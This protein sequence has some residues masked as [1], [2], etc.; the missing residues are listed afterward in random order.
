MADYLTTD[1][2]LTSVADAIRSKGGTSASLVYPSGFVSAIQAISTGTDVSDTTAAAGD[3]RTGKY[4]YTSAGV[5]T[6]GSIA[7]QAAQTITPT[8]SDQT[9]AS[10]KYLTGAQ[11]I[12]GDA[13]LL[14]ENIAEGV[15]I[16]GIQGTH[17]GGSTAIV[18]EKDVN[19]YDFDG[20]LLYAYTAS[21]FSALTELPDLQ[22]KEGFTA[23]GWNW[24]LAGA[25][26]YVQN[27]G[28]LDIGQTCITS[29]G[30]TRIGFYFNLNPSTNK[31]GIPLSQTVS[32]GTVIE[33]GDGNSTTVSG[34]SNQTVYHQ[35]STR[36]K[37]EITI[38]VNSGVLTI[39]NISTYT[40]SDTN[41]G[42]L[43]LPYAY[44]GSNIQVKN[45]I[46]YAEVINLPSGLDNARDSYSG[47]DCL[48]VEVDPYGW[49]RPVYSQYPNARSK[50]IYAETI[51]TLKPLG[52]G[53]YSQC[54]AKITRVTIPAGV[55]A[56]NNYYCAGN[57]CLQYVVI[58]DSVLTVG[59]SAFKSC[60]RLQ[61]VSIP[62]NVT[63]IDGSAFRSCSKLREVHVKA[64][65]PPTLGSSAIP[66][67]TN[68]VIYVPSASLSAYQS[69][70]N[71]SSY[72]SKMVGE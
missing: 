22:P 36:G 63:S 28:M 48:H 21:E 34:T 38:T 47:G 52:S 55:T 20:S 35:Y 17:S 9:I 45:R 49:T 56:V 16:F 12:K 67:N 3:V 43:D 72:A 18:K 46:F 32:G 5:K 37:K 31:L 68:L 60:S 33:W 14:P 65:T 42:D 11:T 29:D 13:N 1:T 66:S 39:D 69:A 58:P 62:A 25:K 54:A 53:D 64:T 7:D 6:Q 59:S 4:F 8:T 15:T 51:N 44:L 30:K 10:G 41:L 70:S 40:T 24:T 23:Q 19:F 2:E 61:Y 57:E 27:Y 50:V 26:T 71:W